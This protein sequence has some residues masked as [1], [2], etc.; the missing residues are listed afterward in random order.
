M[1]KDWR[2]MLELLRNKVGR[3]R[4]YPFVGAAAHRSRDFAYVI[5]LA[6]RVATKRRSDAESAPSQ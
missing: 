1:A 2:D 4:E 6:P 3:D 5:P